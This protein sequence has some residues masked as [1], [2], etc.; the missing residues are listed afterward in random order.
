MRFRLLAAMVIVVSAICGIAATPHGKDAAPVAWD[1]QGSAR[2]LDQ[3]EVWWQGWARS[4]RD[5]GT[6][7]ISCHTQ[8][9]YA[10]GRPVLREALQESALSAPEQ[11]MLGDVRRRVTM[12]NEVAPFYSGDEPTRA[13][14]ARGTEA[15]LNTLILTSYDARKEHLTE[16]TRNAFDSAWA[17]QLTT[18]KDAG[19][20]VWLN[21]HN[22]PWEGEE[23]AY[24]GATYMALAAGMAP[25]GYAR[26][27]TNKA[28]LDL[29]R[30]YLQRNY[31]AQPI[32]NKLVVLWAAA[33]LPGVLT[34]EQKRALAK[35]VFALQ[36]EDGGWSLASFGSW[37]RHDS[38]EEETRSDGY[39]TGLALLA[40]ES[41]GVV[42]NDAR[43][44][45]GLAWLS[46]NQDAADGS[47]H[48]Y[49]LNKQR[50][51]ASDIGKFMSDAA[52]AYA[53]LALEASGTGSR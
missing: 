26:E 14:Q 10:L 52:T 21:F 34:A 39:A 22:A 25:E 3:R 45:K 8:V 30:G 27:P 41:A 19:G 7:C 20:W 6:I 31:D 36:H 33:K 48:A 40:M 42:G 29:L 50:D 37:K 5:H 49:S 46:K 23:S 28:R 18:G 35:D 53:A 15:V 51:Q 1:A 47:W 32:A 9:P 24:Q 16:I 12:W 44:A 43:T 38:S 13:L 2:Y 17:L 11:K 4:G